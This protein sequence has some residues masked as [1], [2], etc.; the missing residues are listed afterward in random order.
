MRSFKEIAALIQKVQSEARYFYL[1]YPNLGGDLVIF[2]TREKCCWDNDQVED[3]DGRVHP[4]GW[5]C[6]YSKWRYLGNIQMPRDLDLSPYKCGD[7]YD[8]HLAEVILDD[9]YRSAEEIELNEELEHGTKKEVIEAAKFFE[10][11]LLV[12][13]AD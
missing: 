6:P 13:V 3:M 5:Y 9:G 10:E 2:F 7:T 11:H 4:F 12:P 1:T 8:L